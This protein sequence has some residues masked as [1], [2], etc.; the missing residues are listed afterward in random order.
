[1]FHFAFQVASFM[2][3]SLGVDRAGIVAAVR[4]YTVPR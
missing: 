1:M 3:E 2:K 4:A